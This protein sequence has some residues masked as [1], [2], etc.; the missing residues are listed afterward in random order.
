MS[1]VAIKDTIVAERVT[2]TGVLVN[3]TW[4]NFSKFG[5]KPALAD[6]GTYEVEYKSFKGKNYIQKARPMSRTATPP[7]N[8]GSTSSNGSVQTY[9]PGIGGN[10]KDKRI[11][12]Q[13]IVQ[14][15]LQSPGLTGFVANAD[16]YLAAV[17]AAAD[18]EIK[19]VLSRAG[20]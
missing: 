13:G 20:E 16:E 6:G 1:E 19:F 14:A 4:W 7:P 2:D 12:V 10:A 18:R 11:L 9:T 3:G 5:K 15:C 17:E 8:A